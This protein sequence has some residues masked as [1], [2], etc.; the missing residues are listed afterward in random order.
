MIDKMLKGMPE[1]FTLPKGSLLS[2]AGDIW[3]EKT[4][5]SKKAKALIEQG[6]WLSKEFDD[7]LGKIISQQRANDVEKLFSEYVDTPQPIENLTEELKQEAFIDQISQDDQVWDEA[8]ATA[9]NAF[10]TGNVDH[11][12]RV[13]KA[14]ANWMLAVR[15][16]RSDSRIAWRTFKARLNKISMDKNK[17]SETCNDVYQQVKHY[18]RS[19]EVGEALLTY[20]QARSQATSD[21]ATAYGELVN[22]LFGSGADAAVGEAT[23][24][25]AEQSAS[26]AFWTSVQTILDNPSQ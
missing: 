22:E 20:E 26:E 14:K 9:N 1:E 23:L 13:Q 8:M 7:H 17:S 4:F 6:D 25:Q 10:V 11:L 24:I 18:R 21:L 16:Y 3:Q 19:S 2:D 12:S 15:K 5:M